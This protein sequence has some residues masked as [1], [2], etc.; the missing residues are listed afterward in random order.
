M[1]FI[2]PSGTRMKISNPSNIYIVT[3][4]SG[5]GKSTAIAAFEDAGFYCVDNMPVALLPNFLSL[6]IENASE[7]SGFAFVM[8][9]REKGFISKYRQVFRSLEEKGFSFEILFLEADENVLL[10]RYSQTRRNHPLAKGKNL[11]EGV[12]AEAVSLAGLKKEAHKIIDTT[13]YTIHELKSCIFN[14]VK[15]NTEIAPIKMN[16]LS[17]GYK[18]GI[19]HHA[20][21]II[22]VR[23]LPNPYFVA[24]L[25]DLDGESDPV[26]KFLSGKT[27]TIKFLEK[28]LDL[29]D[30]LIPLYEKEG[31][32]YLTIAVGCTGGRH[33]SVFIAGE[34]FDHLRQQGRDVTVSHQDIVQND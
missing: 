4:R 34:L 33:R 12:R 11:L 14:I 29:L 23:F 27:E 6:P 5:S 22:D 21:L 15:E 31:K 9:L 8:D 16:V 25:R 1:K 19:P 2:M 26:Q 28:Y 17:F 32:T 10:Q 18:Y 13:Q 24:D 7:I 3:G 30:Y 20:D